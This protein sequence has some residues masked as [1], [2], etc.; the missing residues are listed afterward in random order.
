MSAEPGE[1]REGGFVTIAVAGLALVLVSIATL[2]ATLGAVAVAR[3]RAAAAADLAALSAARHVLEG[4]P[5]ACKA[6]ARTA[7]LQ[8]ALVVSC[9]L[10]GLDAVVEVTVRPAGSLGSLGVG[11]GRARAGPS[12]P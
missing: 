1:V 7:E 12:I 11:H 4:Q 9:V 3:H 8:G 10:L 6:A 2:V 5:A